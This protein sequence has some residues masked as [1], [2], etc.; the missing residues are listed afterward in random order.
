MKYKVSLLI[1]TAF[2]LSNASEMRLRR[3]RSHDDT[4]LRERTCDCSCLE[5][6]A[7][8]GCLLAATSY[9]GAVASEANF[10]DAGL[11]SCLKATTC[12][13][14]TAAPLLY[15]STLNNDTLHGD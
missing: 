7:F 14:G 1:L 15:F 9:V 13:L 4:R 11:V 3:R 8:C 2:T 6:F 10:V 12:I 5:K